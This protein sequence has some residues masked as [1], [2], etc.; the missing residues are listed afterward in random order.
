[1]PVLLSEESNPVAVP[2][3]GDGP[4]TDPGEVTSLVLLEES[5]PVGMLDVRDGLSLDT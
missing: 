5:N 3:A 4:P 2:D 1:M